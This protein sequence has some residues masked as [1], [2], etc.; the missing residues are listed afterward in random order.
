MIPPVQSAVDRGAQMGKHKSASFASSTVLLHKRSVSFYMLLCFVFVG[1]LPVITAAFSPSSKADLETALNTCTG[2]YAGCMNDGTA[3][4]EWDTS[5]IT[6]M[7][8]VNRELLA[9]ATSLLPTSPLPPTIF[10]C[11]CSAS[12]SSGARV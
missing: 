3:I 2:D 8:C 10:P 11:S 9:A 12:P 4:E 1:L 5:E 6:D 7:R